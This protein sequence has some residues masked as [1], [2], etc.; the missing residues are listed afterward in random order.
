MA[1]IR[2]WER[3]CTGWVRAE[4][5]SPLQSDRTA[6]PM[7]SGLQLSRPVETAPVLPPAVKRAV[8]AAPLLLLSA[9]ALL[10]RHI[11]VAL[12]ALTS[13]MPVMPRS[14]ESRSDETCVGMG[15]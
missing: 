1:L 7:M 11:A 6:M 13:A 2:R 4:V 12:R 5:G 9:S 3:P 10:W 8:G 15:P 14:N